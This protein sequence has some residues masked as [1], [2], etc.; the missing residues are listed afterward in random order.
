[1]KRLLWSIALVSLSLISGS[2]FAASYGMA[3]CGVGALV[4]GDQPGKIQILAATLNN[5][6]SPQTSAITSGT[7]N[8]FED[9]QTASA[10]FITV[11]KTALSKDISRG[12]G[13]S[14]AGL[15]KILK[16]SDSDK[17]GNVLQKSYG[18][19]FPSEKTSP[20]EINDSIR[21]TIRSDAELAGTCSAVI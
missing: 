10:M 13:E 1:M 2:A 8:C 14:L 6:I 7:S 5:I 15:S 11:N 3:G 12:S 21:K 19:I 18:E 9:S 20:A 16:C 17:L 4:L